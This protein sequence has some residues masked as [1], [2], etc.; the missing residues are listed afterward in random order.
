MGRGSGLEKINQ[1]LGPFVV[2]YQHSLFA[3]G[4]EKEKVNKNHSEAR[5]QVK[6]QFEKKRSK[7]VTQI[8]ND[9]MANMHKLKESYEALSDTENSV[10]R[11]AEYL[12]FGSVIPQ[13]I[14]RLIFTDCSLPWVMP[15]LGHK[16]VFIESNGDSC[17]ALGLQFV[18]EALKQTAPGQLNISVF[19]PELRPEFYPCSRL[20]GFKMLTGSE[21]IQSE[22]NSLIEEIIQTDKLLQGSFDSLVQLRAATK[23]PVG[24]LRVLVFQDTLSGENKS[25][26][27]AI[28]KIARGAL[29]AGIVILFLNSKSISRNVRTVKA[30]KEIRHFF[31]LTQSGNEWKNDEPL[32]EK[33]IFT[34][35]KKN[36]D[37][38]AK[39]ID[40]IVEESKKTS[41]VTIP[42]LEIEDTTE[43]WK[44]KSIG[45]L[46]FHLGKAGLEKVSVCIGD[47][48]SQH[49]NILISGAAGQGK[50]NL[51]EV[52]IHSLCER[53]SPE[54]LELYLLDF[55]DGLT[56]KP[57]ASF[58]D[59]TWLP[60]AKML[61]LESDRD[62][63]VAVLKDI[64]AERKRRA[65]LFKNAGGGVHDFE[66][67][68]KQNAQTLLP[69]VVL[70]ID[71]YQKLFDVNDDVSTEAAD[72]LENLVRQGRACAI[73][74]ILASQSITGTIGLMGREDRIYGQFPVRIALKNTLTESHSI[75][76]IGNDAASKLRVRGEAVINENYGDI[77]SNKRFIVAYADPKQMKE[78][79]HSF[80]SD[81]KS[82]RKPVIF[83]RNDVIDCS[84]F[85]DDLK[86]W[87]KNVSKG[88]TI[89]IPLG[90]E[91]SV[92]KTVLP[93]TFSN[94]IGKNIAI[95]GAAED[96][97]DQGAVSGKKH[98]ALG[99]IQ[100][101]GL[102]LA[103]Q[104][105]DGNARFVFL[106]GLASDVW[107]NS[108]MDRWLRLMERFGFPVEVY[109]SNYAA[110]WL[111]SFRQEADCEDEDVYIICAGMDRFSSFSESNLSGESGTSALQ[112]LHKAGA[113]RV[114]FICWWSS[115]SVYKSHI[116]F[117]GEGYYGTKVLLR[118]D[119]DSAREVL[120]PFAQW[121]IKENRAYIHDTS[122]LAS[123]AVVMPI[124]PFTD[125]ICGLIE[126]ETW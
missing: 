22:L 104:H 37:E 30:V 25:I 111:M 13:G 71:E 106:N 91:V 17:Q 80:C 117:D 61:G 47:S 60:H 44:H 12:K 58:S 59:E 14:D 9:L 112:E 79:R 8:T 98:M 64:E 52:M 109:D 110:E 45:D 32:F 93:I 82:G 19:N 118:M 67:F 96:L 41:A 16:C 125:R 57:Y 10:I 21:E 92:K 56:F 78:L 86:K 84:I 81:Y 121:G 124:N 99:M 62:I 7:A 6:K 65:S 126:S 15:F 49:H 11:A 4:Q 48:V 1:L 101:I 38:I 69:R 119:S 113:R 116:G 34:F 105:P 40:E 114:H 26:E 107:K 68:R 53:Y 66:S 39:I 55:K 83:T 50:S 95:L 72:L 23:Q 33:L 74:V 85:I 29:R 28:I 122:D 102:S 54:E 35:P 20:P 87:R 2:A 89:R 18:V 90:V 100:G 76:T 73:H 36:N 88:E 123:D 24:Q 5:D 3:I 51:I 77:N 27:N 31:R 46:T 42:F 75:F 94:D 120:G 43:K 63:G 103:L 115:I 108:N 97:S 70:V